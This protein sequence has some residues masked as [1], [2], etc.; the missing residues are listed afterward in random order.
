VD[1]EGTRKG[2]DVELVQAVSSAVSVPIIASGGMGSF[3]DLLRVT[4]EGGAD[5]VAMADIVHY[6][7]LDFATIRSEAIDS[8]LGVRR[9]EIPGDN[10][11]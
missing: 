1:R 5:A 11:N 10:D 2:F 3:Q 8:G 6:G 9:Y 7:R 4:S